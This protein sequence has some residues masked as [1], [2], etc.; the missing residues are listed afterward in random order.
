MISPVDVLPARI[1]QGCAN[2]C[3][4]CITRHTAALMVSRLEVMSI[5]Q[6]KAL[7]V[8]NSID[9][10]ADALCCACKQ[11]KVGCV[12]HL[13][14][15]KVMYNRHLPPQGQCLPCEQDQWRP[16]HRVQGQ[17]WKNLQP[18]QV[19]QVTSKQRCRS[20]TKQQS[21]NEGTE[22]THR[23]CNLVLHGFGSY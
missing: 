22:G 16:D 13:T 19:I 6:N 8:D 7:H 21:P 20:F 14:E 10:L 15:A 2:H 5:G 11:A 17:I 3:R 4:C 1:H 12:K 9:Y 18:A 23:C